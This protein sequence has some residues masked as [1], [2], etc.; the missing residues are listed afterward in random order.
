M[1][2]LHSSGAAAAHELAGVAHQVGEHLA[3]DR[4]QHGLGLV[5][6]AACDLGASDPGQA[7]DAAQRAA[8]VVRDAA[9]EALESGDVFLQVRRALGDALLQRLVDRWRASR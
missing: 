2:P 5:E 3:L 9:V 6:L 1:A 7:R 8:Q 4:G